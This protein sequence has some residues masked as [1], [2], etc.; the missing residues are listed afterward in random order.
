MCL[1]MPMKILSINEDTAVTEFGGVEYKVNIRL[2]PDAKVNDY[3]IVHAGFAI[4]KLDETEA[5]ETLKLFN[6]LE[7]DDVKIH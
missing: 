3:I 2:V 4:Q 1:A 7:K 6:E 5:L